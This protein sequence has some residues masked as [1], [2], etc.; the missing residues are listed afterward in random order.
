MQMSGPDDT[1]LERLEST[2][3]IRRNVPEQHCSQ[4]PILPFTFWGEAIIHS[5]YIIAQLTPSGTCRASHRWSSQAYISP[6]H[7]LVYSPLHTLVSATGLL[8]GLINLKSLSLKLSKFLKVICKLILRPR[9]PCAEKYQRMHPKKAR[10]VNHTSSSL[11]LPPLQSLPLPQPAPK[12]QLFQSHSNPNLRKATGSDCGS[13]PRLRQRSGSSSNVPP[14]DRI[15]L[16]ISTYSSIVLDFEQDKAIPPPV[17]P[18]PRKYVPKPRKK[19]PSQTVTSTSTTAAVTKPPLPTNSNKAQSRDNGPVL[20]LHNHHP[21]LLPVPPR[22]PRR[23]YGNSI[24]N[25]DLDLTSDPALRHHVFRLRQEEEEFLRH[26]KLG[27]VMMMNEEHVSKSEGA[28]EDAVK[29]FIDEDLSLLDNYGND[30]PTLFNT[31]YEP[32][33][34]TTTHSDSINLTPTSSRASM[35]TN[36]TNVTDS[37]TVNSPS[38]LHTPKGSDASV[39]SPMRT[40]VSPA[41]APSSHSVG[42]AGRFKNRF[43]RHKNGDAGAVDKGRSS[44]GASTKAS[45]STSSFRSASST[46]Q[47]KSK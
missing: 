28:V 8:S 5:R 6:L 24:D 19:G 23:D 9:Q 13:S 14:P 33:S 31:F 46:L 44:S 16:G 26:H 11:P 3:H 47:A 27:L 18:K 39:G 35:T 1:P 43:A 32:T 4:V 7:L 34:M 30:T 17:P 2:A 12:R 42:F 45:T 41:R 25:F 29:A 40:P 15:G 10:R 22:S 20:K 38:S 37:A 36:S 21:S